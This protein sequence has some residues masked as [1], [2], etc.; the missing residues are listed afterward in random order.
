M[1]KAYLTVTS[2]AGSSSQFSFKFNPND[3]TV[4]KSARWSRA[5]VAAVGQTAPPQF[6]GSDPRTIR[7][8]I[9]LDET[10]QTDT[11]VSTS[12]NSL[13]SCL[14]PTEDSISSGKPSPPTVVFGWG[15]TVWFSAF[16]RDIEA[17]VTLFRTD[18]TPI[19]AAC[20]LTLEEIPTSTPGQNPTSGSLSAY[21]THTVVAGD[22]LASVAYGAYGKAD[23]WRLIAEANEID[24]PTRLRTGRSL[25]IPPADAR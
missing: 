8:E 17:Q 3:Y 9:F 2:S 16:V 11:S 5:R 4:S 18:G 24:D 21:R 20:M 23:R 12:L 1:E 22:T 10:D 13:F 19:R 25:L 6:V 14:A 7:L 15:S